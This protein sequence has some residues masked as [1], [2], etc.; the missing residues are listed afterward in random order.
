MTYF[1]HSDKFGS[2]VWDSAL[3]WTASARLKRH[4]IAKGAS[5]GLEDKTSVSSL[6]TGRFPPMREAP[7]AQS[8][9]SPRADMDATGSLCL[10]CS[11]ASQEVELSQRH[12]QHHA[13]LAGPVYLHFHYSYSM[14]HSGVF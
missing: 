3:I 14:Y 6:Q 12:A 4:I 9:F 2:F 1:F 10:C 5:V 13:H 11:S 7:C 8:G